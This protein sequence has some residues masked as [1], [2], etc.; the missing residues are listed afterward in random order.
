M[1]YLPLSIL[2]VVIINKNVEFVSVLTIIIL[3]TLF[4]LV[5]KVDIQLLLET[6]ISYNSNTELLY[7]MSNVAINSVF[8]LLI[9]HLVLVVFKSNAHSYLELQNTKYSAFLVE[10]AIF[11]A[12]YTYNVYYLMHKEYT[13]LLH[14]NIISLVHPFI[15]IS[16]VIIITI[17]MYSKKKASL[18]TTSYYTILTAIILGMFWAATTEGWGGAWAWDPTEIIILILAVAILTVLHFKKRA[19]HL[20]YYWM[21]PVLFYY[22]SINK[23]SLVSGI[24]NFYLN[25]TSK[26]THTYYF[27]GAIFIYIVFIFIKSG[28]LKNNGA[29]NYFTSV[30]II[31]TIVFFIRNYNWWSNCFIF[32]QLTIQ[33]IIVIIATAILVSITTHHIR[34]VLCVTILAC[35]MLVTLVV[36]AY[37]TPVIL[38]VIIAWVLMTRLRVSNWAFINHVTHFTM[39]VVILY[40]YTEF[41]SNINPYLISYYHDN[42]LTY[43]FNETIQ[44]KMKSS[45]LLS[46]TK[47]VNDSTFHNETWMRTSFWLEQTK[48]TLY[49]FQTNLVS[50]VATSISSPYDYNT[51]PIQIYVA[52]TVNSFSNKVILII[53]WLLLFSYVKQKW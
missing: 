14:D 42:L 48:N 47:N 15:T 32:N 40:N 22:V 36:Q 49:Q 24:H 26:V 28:T 7:V 45:Y 21:L 44:Q 41:T 37:P 33:N 9:I 2:Y 4:I 12:M 16:A 8:F 5:K 10:S 38:Y 23:L 34:T 13:F 50:V 20:T 3:L 52:H 17:S 30:L 43:S 39:G 35:C 19:Y 18:L 6:N 25:N 11:Y 46:K 27:I 51:Y 53:Y 1:N 31:T 29:R